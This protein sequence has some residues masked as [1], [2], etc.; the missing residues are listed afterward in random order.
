M[1]LLLFNAAFSA[2]VVGLIHSLVS[3]VYKREVFY[4]VAVAAIGLG[5]A[6]HTS[7]LIV[8]GFEKGHFPLTD[9]RESLAFFAWAVCLCFLIAYIRYSFKA[10]GLFLLP[11]V[12]VL[13]LG[14]VV[15]KASPVPTIFKSYW[16]VFHTTFI[17]LAYGMLFVTFV[18][19]LLYLMQERELK[20]KRP[21]T[22]F[23]RLPSLELLD[24]LFVKFLVAG[25][26][27][28]T[29]GLMAGIIFAEKDLVR[30]W[31]TDPKVLSAGVTWV[32][33]LALIYLR[34]TAGLRGKK[35]ALLSVAGFVSAIFAFLGAN[36]F[37]GLHAF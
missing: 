19:G 32:I 16:I 24:E 4:R 13:M 5:F 29:I 8:L 1:S 7:F 22:L 17:F 37:G 20:T 2:Y 12:T 35:A 33:Y 3:F 25:F 30:G 14:T 11:L 28:M 21:R 10:L 34:L 36:Y 31:Q 9:L 27:F 6:L 18:S 23:Y 26:C 15:L